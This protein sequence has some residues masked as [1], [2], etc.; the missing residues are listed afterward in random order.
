MLKELTKIAN[1]L[2]QAGL[3]KEAD[4]IDIIIKKIAQELSYG[5]DVSNI[6][7]EFGSWLKSKNILISGGVTPLGPNGFMDGVTFDIYRASV[8]ELPEF[9]LD[10]KISGL[11]KR[12]FAEKGRPELLNLIEHID[13]RANDNFVSAFVHFDR[14]DVTVGPREPVLPEIPEQ[15]AIE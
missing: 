8:E 10:D 13:A 1:K 11:M 5:N 14:G 9:N 3:T 2:D 6:L 15:A 12:F 4:K 7:E